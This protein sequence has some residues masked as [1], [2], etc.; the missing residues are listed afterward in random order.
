[1]AFMRVKASCSPVLAALFA[2]AAPAAAGTASA[3]D[4]AV[5]ANAVSANAASANAASARPGPSLVHADIVALD[6]IIVYNRFGSFDPYGMIF[7]LRRDVSAAAD[8]GDAQDAGVCAGKTGVEPGSGALAPGKVRLKDCKRPRPLVLRA[9]VGDVLRIN[10]A[11]LLRPDQPG[12]SETFCPTG[13]R[14]DAG[15]GIGTIRG[16]VSSYQ[17]PNLDGAPLCNRPGIPGAGVG[18]SGVT[19][20]G[21]SADWPRTRLLSLAIPGIEPIPA[22]GA[23]RIDDV[24]KGL[25]G[26]APGASATCHYRLDREGTHLFQSMAAPAGGEG[27]G[28]SLTHGLFGALIVEPAGSNFYRSQVPQ[29]AFDAVWPRKAG[30]ET[31]ARDGT[32]VFDRPL[33]SATP[34]AQRSAGNPCAA[35][36]EV[37]VAAML[38]ACGSEEAVVLD[39]KTLSLPTQ[40]I[41]HADINA[42]IVPPQA[43][44][45]SASAP[46][47][48]GDPYEGDKPAAEP[49]REFVVIFHD[50]LKTYYTKHLEGLASFEQFSGIRDGFGINYGASGAGSLVLANR[51]KIGPAASCPECMYEE[52]FLESWANGDPAL[53]ENFA[54]DPSNV[55]HSYLND[56]VVFR[57]FH[58][59]PKETHVFHLHSH[60]WFAGNDK[61][62][63]AYLD[64]QTIGPQQGMSYDIYG[65]G[66]Q[67]YR[68]GRRDGGKAAK[69]WYD[70]LGSGNRNR[71]PG[72]AIFHC[73]LYPHFAQGMWELWRVHDVL[74]DG[75]RTLPDGQRTPGLSLAPRAAAERGQIRP[76]TP[77]EGDGPALWNGDRAAYSAE[78]TPIPGLLPVPLQA[79]PLLPTYDR[80]RGFPGYP[81][82]IAGTPGHRSP[83]APMDIAVEDGRRLDGGLGRHVVTGGTRISDIAAGESARWA[84]AGIAERAGIPYFHDAIVPLTVAQKLALGDLTETYHTLSIR[85]LPPDGTRLER[86]AMAFHHTGLMEGRAASPLLLRRADGTEIVKLP[87][88]AGPLPPA[89]PGAPSDTASGQERQDDA[90]TLARFRQAL[91]YESIL[92]PVAPAP[93]GA[94]AVALAPFAVNGA[95][96]KPGAP[97]AD[98]CG[99]PD[100]LRGVAIRNLLGDDDREGEVALTGRPYSARKAMVGGGDKFGDILDPD[101]PKA[102]MTYDPGLSGFRRFKASVIEFDMV[103][104]KAG[105]HDPQARINVLTRVS[106]LYK[107]GGPRA[108]SG[109]EDPFYFRAFSGDC[110]EFRHTN[111]TPHKLDLDDF[112]AKVPT[113]TIGQHIHLVKFDV[114]S[115]D[116]SGNGWN[117]EDGTFAPDELKERI[118]AARRQEELNT[119]TGWSVHPDNDGFKNGKPT[120]FIDLAAFK[121]AVGPG[122]AWGKSCG[123]AKKVW[124]LKRSEHPECF[125]TTTQRWFADPI[126][127]RTGEAKGD[128]YADRTLRTVFTHDHFAPS[129]IQQHGF[130][131]ALLIE[132]VSKDVTVYATD[133]TRT[134]NAIAV[135]VTER[136]AAFAPWAAGGSGEPEPV[137]VDA[138]RPA[139]PSA[140]PPENGNFSDNGVGA[141]ARVE[142]RRTG[143]PAVGL[144]DELHPNYREFALAIADFALLYDGRSGTVP[145]P[146]SVGALDGGG[147]ADGLDRLIGEARL[148]YDDAVAQ[149]DADASGE[150]KA[151]NICEHNRGRLATANPQGHRDGRSIAGPDSVPPAQ[152]VACE[153][154]EGRTPPAWLAAAADQLKTAYF[155]PIRAAHGK[156]VY[157]PPRPE[158]ISQMHHDPYLVNYRNEPMPLRIGETGSGADLLAGRSCPQFGTPYARRPARAHAESVARQKSDDKADG[159]MARVFRS[160]EHG[161]PCTPVLEAYDGERVMFRLIQGAQEVQHVFTV[162]GRPFRRNVDQPFAF[163]ARLDAARSKG[164][165]PTR[166]NDCMR[167]AETGRPLQFM[168]WFATFG[169][170]SP[171][172]EWLERYRAIA[173]ECDNVA[174]YVTAQEVGISEHFEF[175]GAFSSSSGAFGESRMRVLAAGERKPGA[176][177]LRDALYHFGSVD[178]QW[179]GGWGLIRSF[180][181]PSAPDT[182]S[183]LIDSSLH[184]GDDGLR[185]RDACLTGEA[186]LDP[187]GRR[188]APIARDLQ[189]E[190]T[191]APAPTIQVRDATAAGTLSR[192]EAPWALPSFPDLSCPFLDPSEMAAGDN[193]GGFAPTTHVFAA[194]AAFETRYLHDGDPLGGTVYDAKAGLYDPDGLAFVALDPKALGLSHPGADPRAAPAET[195]ILQQERAG[196]L[197]DAGRFG[198]IPWPRL[199]ALAQTAVAERGL[200]PHVQ[201]INA[202]DCLH[203]VVINGLTETPLP[204]PVH[205]DLTG[206]T[207]SGLR[208]RPGDALL[209]RITRLNSDQIKPGAS[210]AQDG[211]IGEVTPSAALAVA[212]P[213][214]LMANVNEVPDPVGANPRLALPPAQPGGAAPY[215]ILT[216]YAGTAGSRAQELDE[217]L[218]NVREQDLPGLARG[219]AEQASLRFDRSLCHV[220][221]RVAGPDGSERLRRFGYAVWPSA[222]A[223]CR[224]PDHGQIELNVLGRRYCAAIAEQPDLNSVR[225]DLAAAARDGVRPDHGQL[226]ACLRAAVKHAAATGDLT[227]RV[228]PQAFGTLPLKSVADP[229][230]HGPHGLAGIVIVEPRS[231]TYGAPADTRAAPAE[232]S[233]PGAAVPGRMRMREGPG[234]RIE[235]DLSN[236]S[237]TRIDRG[238]AAQIPSAVVEVKALTLAT[239]PHMPDYAA[240]TVAGAR[241]YETALLWQDGLNLWDARRRPFYSGGCVLG[242]PGCSNAGDP[243]MRNRIGGPVPDCIVCD[244]SYDRG[245]KG[246]SYRTDALFARLRGR[247]ST[248]PPHPG[249]QATDHQSGSAPIPAT[250]GPADWSSRSGVPI[251]HG[252]LGR[253]ADGTFRIDRTSDLNAW[254]LPAALFSRT[255]A[256]VATPPITAPAGAQML[257]RMVEPQGRARQ[258]AFVPTGVGYQDIFP[259]FGSGHST[260][261]APGKGVSAAMEAPATPGDYLWFDGPRQLLNG[262]A[263]GLF[264]I[265]GDGHPCPARQD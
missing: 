265:S 71:T 141:Q 213:L 219:T 111:E 5:S 28:G 61:N 177:P 115:S 99:A 139:A 106:D 211:S 197:D 247:T 47:G 263:W 76:G 130:Y 88:L 109:K 245:E 221:R 168:R 206:N 202:G 237:W 160:A 113:D 205:G 93:S 73:H 195:I 154:H 180:A 238:A 24:C 41:V 203:L 39:G 193:P 116:G 157:P 226:Q 78:G 79:A 183:C 52:F 56:R 50:E 179:N 112:Q 46:A 165:G 252:G 91:G 204:G 127:S 136:R 186:N 254:A 135:D 55:H 16:H 230:S 240:E 246:V 57:N 128:A 108:T 215:T 149:A 150:E 21:G 169:R 158:A 80:E 4:N 175:A 148:D 36:A 233:D 72:D 33:A 227:L 118:H 178:A 1:M 257:V 207:R 182:T 82:Y 217:T 174:G 190:A 261:L 162:E 151:R 163:A 20:P 152:A 119:G 25:G 6:Q 77:A 170:T 68:P 225:F 145:S 188:L 23:A 11:N 242:A 92:V 64:S 171:S 264:C 187:V 58:A 42:I 75:T 208:D 104:N 223:A 90:A 17:D 122:S 260:L 59:G 235:H 156:P 10:L 133:V 224:A 140:A 258:R 3:A 114:T 194:V 255:F 31:H 85:L 259:G 220:D 262:G 51:Q 19:T 125:Q 37:P 94:P 243:A 222:K 69:G 107:P 129:N 137:L 191:A 244:D 26:I 8:L 89:V 105:W 48:G 70:T 250:I 38:R 181:D 101:Y 30:G 12:I 212:L 200:V 253:D 83:Q 249:A 199:R 66:A 201:R 147:E 117:Y 43:A 103:V 81:F 97:F 35:V 15:P 209:P 196:A 143:D 172:G 60:Q 67:V 9:R 131:N 18:E 234:P 184:D 236:P 146:G 144:A 53:L 62:R 153:I 185:R 166:W 110:I 14:D 100:S 29:A 214:P 132:P 216:F 124:A 44:S 210:D 241:I 155:D 159:D 102:D 164:K 126:L 32:P 142:A 176:L 121:A 49:F 54:D 239:I 87:G 167:A 2:L 228:V 74:E 232:V 231:A 65:G 63:G 34:A 251:Y 7:A 13:S 27:D 218:E 95:P 189:A 192:S 248:F 173:A 86:R 123:A 84:E 161:D 256:P 229:V 22:P 198:D 138:F 134:G 45:A 40:E 98:P 120:N 96:P